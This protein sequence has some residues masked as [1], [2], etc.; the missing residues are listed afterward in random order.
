MVGTWQRREY[1]IH[2]KGTLTY[3][4]VGIEDH[5]KKVL[6]LQGC[7]IELGDYGHLKN[8]L[9]EEFSTDDQTVMKILFKDGT[10][11]EFITARAEAFCFA[12]HLVTP[13][14]RNIEVLLTS[15]Y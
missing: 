7:T 14:N 8:A 12:I 1:K 11:L 6:D 3:S 13:G 2:S 15:H 10:V 5:D 9:G 4:E